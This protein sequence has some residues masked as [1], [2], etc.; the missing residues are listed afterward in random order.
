MLR[1]KTLQKLR[2][3]TSQRGDITRIAGRIGIPI[4]TLWR[5]VN[6]KFSGSA[7]TWDAIFRYYG[8]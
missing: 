8:K 6:G 5:I 4:V 1:E 2:V 7:K 3:E